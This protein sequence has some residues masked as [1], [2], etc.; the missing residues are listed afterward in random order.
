MIHNYRKSRVR[1]A[2]GASLTPLASDTGVINGASHARGGVDLGSVEVEGQEVM[3]QNPDGSTNV[4]SDKLGYADAIKPLANRKGQLE[5]ILARLSEQEQILSNNTG[6]DIPERNTISTK[7]LALNIQK[8]PIIEEIQN[9]DAQM[10]QLFQMQQQENGGQQV[11]PEGEIQEQPTMEKGGKIKRYGRRSWKS[12]Y[13]IDN[14]EGVTIDSEYTHNGINGSNL[15]IGGGKYGTI[16]DSNNEGGIKGGIRISNEGKIDGA[17]VG[18]P[19]RFGRKTGLA[20]TP[21]VNVDKDINPTINMNTKLNTKVGKSS[22]VGANSNTDFNGNYDAGVY[23]NTSVGNNI[24][25]GGYAGYGN[26]GATGNIS[27]IKKFA[28]GGKLKIPQLEATPAVSESSSV[29]TPVTPRI[30]QKV[31]LTNVSP[32]VNSANIRPATPINYTPMPKPVSQEEENARFQKDFRQR[33]GYPQSGAITPDY[34]IEKTAAAFMLP[35][36]MST[37]S[38]VANAL[39][40]F[41]IEEALPVVGSKGHGVGTALMHYGRNKIGA[42]GVEKALHKESPKMRVGGRIKAWN[43]IKLKGFNNNSPQ[44]EPIKPLMLDQFAVKNAMKPGLNI[45]TSPILEGNTTTPKRKLSISFDKEGIGNMIDSTMPFIDNVG[46]AILNSATPQ[47]PAP[48]MTKVPRINT[49]VDVSSDVNTVNNSIDS[50]NKMISNY[51]SN[52]T[53]NIA[54]NSVRRINAL[55]PI[56]QNRNN[57]ERELQNRQLELIG[58]ND[59][60][61]SAKLDNYAMEKA[62]RDAGVLNDTS[63]NLADMAKDIISNREFKANQDYQN[64]WLDVESDKYG[65]NMFDKYLKDYTNEDDYIKA[66]KQNIPSMTEEGERLNRARFRNRRTNKKSLVSISRK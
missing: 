37:S 28:F 25:L 6:L 62:K 56:Y 57:Q 61:N 41:A 48:T 44:L 11:S 33:T 20:V 54:A 49:K 32:M 46:N 12:G 38:K 3:K 17:Y 29:V 52:P 4:Y 65:N 10:Q 66:L 59:A 27:L 34:T 45:G 30:R 9:I 8:K 40:D 60:S 19:M 58:A 7:I 2:N 50:A 55:N 53:A 47:V 26:K 18:I 24:Y 64:K 13:N 35:G 14:S 51:S 15:S 23:G 1:L 63:A 42:I 21:S 5:Q 36:L 31:S 16:G 22:Y 43:G 39:G